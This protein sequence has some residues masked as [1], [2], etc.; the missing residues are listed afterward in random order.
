METNK[1]RMGLNSCTFNQ[2]VNCPTILLIINVFSSFKISDSHTS[3]CFW[4]LNSSSRECKED[5]GWAEGLSGCL[6]T[7]SLQLRVLPEEPAF[8][9]GKF[10]AFLLNNL[11][12]SE[13]KKN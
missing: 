8:F 10:Q 5:A 4:Y 1:N 9:W 2:K 6:L 12:R 3:N 7:T 13:P 11:S